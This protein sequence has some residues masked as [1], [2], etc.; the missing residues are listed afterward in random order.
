MSPQTDGR[1]AIRR[2]RP[3][4]VEFG[5]VT[6]VLIGL[7]L[8]QR[9]VSGVLASVGSPP[10]NVLV[11]GFVSGGLLLL[12]TLLFT[13]AYATSR[14]IDLG[15]TVPT[16]ADLPAVALA[17]LVPSTLVALTKLV[18]VVTGVPYNALTKTAV[19][20]DP[21]LLPVAFIAGLGLL[22]GVPGLVAVCQVL[23]QESIDRVV[24]GDAAVVLTTLA[25]GFVMVSTAGGLTTVPDRGK[26]A[27]VAVFVLLLGVALAADTRCNRDWVRWLATAPVVAFAPLVV[28]SGIAGVDSVAGCLFAATQLATLGVAAYTY[29]RT[30]SLYLPALA[31]ASLLLSNR[32][33]IVGFEAG[34]RSW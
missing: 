34:M 31:Y 14:G 24:D 9:L 25:T 20:A 15:L 23:V 18:G 6:A 26:L 11:G 28:L 29:D 17:V 32:I 3:L 7:S 19:A 10:G 30:D 27:G 5:I 22:V 12:G 8:W 13:G 16:I 4:A 1:A 2:A 33:V 21:P